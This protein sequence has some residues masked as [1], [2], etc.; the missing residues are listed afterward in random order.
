M[1]KVA[2]T[3]AL[4]LL[5]LSVKLG[6]AQ[7]SA[8]VN[9]KFGNPTAAEMRMTTCSFDADAKAVVLCSVTD[10]AYKYVGE[11]MRVQ[12]SVKQRIKVLTQEGVDAANVIIPY[13]STEGENGDKEEIVSLK[14]TAYNLVNG[15]VVKTKMTSD[16]V[17]DERLDKHHMLK[18]FTIPQVKAGTVLEYQYVKASDFCYE[19]DDWYAQGELPVVYCSCEVSIPEWYEFSLEQTGAQA[20]ESKMDYGFE[21]SIPSEN[22]VKTKCYTFKGYNLPAIKGDRYVWCTQTYACKVGFELGGIFVP[23]TIYKKYTTTWQDVDKLLMDDEDFGRRIKRSNPLKD[24]MVAAGIDRMSNFEEKVTATINL[25]RKH[26]KWNG[27]YALLGNPSSKVLKEGKANNADINFLLMNMLKSVGVN[28]DPLVLRTR[29]K[30]VLPISHPSV[31]D[32]N[33][34]VVGIFENDSTMHL[35]DGSAEY[36]YLDILPPTLLTTA[37]VFYGG[38][39]NLM[40]RANS[41]EVCT[42][43]GSLDSNGQLKGTM[44]TRYQ[45]V[46]SLLKKR[47]YSEAKDSTDYVKDLAH[48]Y[49]MTINDYQLKEAHH[50]SPFAEQNIRFEKDNEQGDI[51]YFSPILEMPF[52]ENPFTSAT[53]NLPV[54]FDSPVLKSYAARILLPA[55][56][57]IEEMPKPVMMRSADNGLSFRMQIQQ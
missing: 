47:S 55:N 53:R 43:N 6:M 16:M 37:H 35:F 52:T 11:S 36:G 31:N 32:L 19:I 50:Y 48:R 23:G 10:V 21:P 33:T 26:V 17:F 2:R 29:N 3:F 54:E 38:T 7:G 18:K 44:S 22:P 51:I 1:K 13:Y 8:Q 25:L 28:A 27:R 20:L 5:V 42:V 56:Y 24:E 30:G 46:S 49:Q 40:N 45:G 14:A 15:K 4:L 12:Y 57:Q 39:I 9:L 34:F 41:R